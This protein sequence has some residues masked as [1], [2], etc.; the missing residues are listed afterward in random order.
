MNK[1]KARA[2]SAILQKRILPVL[3]GARTLRIARTL[4]FEDYIATILDKH[5]DRE[6][7]TIFLTSIHVDSEGSAS[8]TDASMFDYCSKAL[9]LLERLDSRKPIKIETSNFGGDLYHGLGIYDRI[10]LSPCHIIMHGYG[11]IMSAGSL[12][13]QAGDKRL[14]SPNATMMLHYADGIIENM[15][16]QSRESEIQEHRRVDRCLMEIYSSRI[17][18]AG[19]AISKI[20]LGK[21]IKNTLYMTAVEAIKKGLADGIILNP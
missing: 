12:I 14:L 9:T 15:R 21:E 19:K 4:P 13:F 8:G 16:D 11:P 7:R 20:A 17:K 2:K 3:H 6:A 1:N 10:K 18:Q 5:V